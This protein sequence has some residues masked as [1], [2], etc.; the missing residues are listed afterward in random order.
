MNS[1]RQEAD[2]EL[3]G[4]EEKLSSPIV[5]SRFG[6]DLHSIKCSK[7]DWVQQYEAGVFITFTALPDGN[8]GVRRIR[9]R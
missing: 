5:F 3:R 7:V 1:G 8:T 9:F 6:D 4:E 2:R